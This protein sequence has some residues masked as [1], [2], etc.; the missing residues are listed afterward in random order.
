MNNCY[1][2]TGQSPNFLDADIITVSAMD[3]IPFSHALVEAK[4]CTLKTNGNAFVNFGAGVLPGTFYYLK[5]NHKN[6][7]ETWSA[8][9]LDLSVT[10]NY[11]FISAQSQA[12]ASNQ[13][14]TF[15]ALFAAMFC[16]DIDQ[17]GAIDGSDFIVFDGPNQAGAGGYQLSD[18]NGDGAVD[19]SDFL[20]YDPNNQNGVG[21]SVPTP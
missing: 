15:D 11:S 21:V 17:D 16:G 3:A 13:A 10:P 19:G 14:I 7:V 2:I 8:T 5:I 4:V 9:A 18:L 1:F 12:Y 20:I 6:H